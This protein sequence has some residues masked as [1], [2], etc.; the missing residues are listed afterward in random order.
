MAIDADTKL[1]PSWLI[2]ERHVAD[3]K[4]FVDDLASRLSGRLQVTTDGRRACVE[5]VDTAFGG[6]VDYAVL[7]KLYGVDPEA[8]KQYSPAKCIGVDVR[9]VSSDPNP[10]HI[11][12]SYVERQNLTMKMGCAG[13]PAWP[14]PSPRR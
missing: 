11:S 9:V 10:A 13:S 4:A 12:T 8:E 7:Q 14:T 2:G 6:R 1:A 3:A 5:A